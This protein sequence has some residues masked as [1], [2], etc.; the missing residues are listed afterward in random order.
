MIAVDTNIIIRFLT[1]DDNEQYKKA[2]DLFNSYDVF[3][4]DS[5]ILET[6][7]VL[8][9]AYKFSS[10]EIYKALIGL[11]GLKTVILTNPTSIAQT[12]D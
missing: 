8:R 6:E 4:A 9:F 2:F 12:I 11:F 5:V 1:Q 7:W 10:T 3:I